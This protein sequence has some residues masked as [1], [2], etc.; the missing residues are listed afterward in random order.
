MTIYIKTPTVSTSI[1]SVI[2][3]ALRTSGVTVKDHTGIPANGTLLAKTMYPNLETFV[4]N[5]T[6]TRDTP[7]VNGDEKKTYEYDLT[8]RYLHCLPAGGVGGVYD[9]YAGIF[10]IRTAVFAAFLNNSGNISGAVKAE[11]KGATKPGP[12]TDPAGNT[13]WG[14]DFTIRIT[15]FCEVAP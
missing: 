2:G 3:A 7:G 1:T 6:I 5:E 10:V 11:F 4:S 13:F 15:E 14:C 8:Y 9:V 12:V